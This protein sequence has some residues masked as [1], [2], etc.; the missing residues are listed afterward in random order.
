MNELLTLRLL[1]SILYFSGRGGGVKKT[2]HLIY[3]LQKI[4]AKSK[5]RDMFSERGHLKQ[6]SFNSESENYSHIHVQFCSCIEL[7][8]ELNWMACLLGV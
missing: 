7:V 8:F 3:N 4:I 2:K 6:K 5:T 1:R